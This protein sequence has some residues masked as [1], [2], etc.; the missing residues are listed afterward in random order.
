VGQPPLLDDVVVVAD[1]SGRFIGLDRA[2]GKPRGPGYTLK[3]SAAPAADPVL[4]GSEAA[5]IP[6]T[7]GTV[8]LLTLRH[9]LDPLAALP[10]VGR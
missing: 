9:L 2:T 6:L 7:D 1:L 4:F 3:A 5:F 10:T 8:F